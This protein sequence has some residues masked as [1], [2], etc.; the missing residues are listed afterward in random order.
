[1]ASRT[2]LLL[3]SGTPALTET[4]EGSHSMRYFSTALSRPGRGGPAS[5]QWAT[6]TTRSSCGSTATRRVRGWSRRRR[7]WSRSGRSI[8]TGAHG[9]PRSTHR[10]TE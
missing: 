10:L 5:L 7:G 6:W 2:L 3:L 8:G 4:W 9:T 1:M